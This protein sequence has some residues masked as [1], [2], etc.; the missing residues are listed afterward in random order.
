MIESPSTNIEEGKLIQAYINPKRII[1][2]IVAETEENTFT[3][4]NE[5]GEWF[6][7]KRDNSYYV[8]IGDCEYEVFRIT[9]IDT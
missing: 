1:K 8:Q 3:V 6:F 2:G 5:N 9:S 7:E 4:E